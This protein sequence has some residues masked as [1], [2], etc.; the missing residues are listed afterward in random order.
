MN[1]EIGRYIPRSSSE[2]SIASSIHD[3]RIVTTLALQLFWYN[4]Y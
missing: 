1:T 4:G 3:V 2:K